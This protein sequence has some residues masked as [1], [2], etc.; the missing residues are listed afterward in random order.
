[1]IVDSESVCKLRLEG[2]R[3]HLLLEEEGSCCTPR[4]KMLDV[5]QIEEGDVSG[6]KWVDE[7]AAAMR[8]VCGRLGSRLVWL[9]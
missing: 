5:E 8:R 1:M 2:S 4:L 6:D 7:T 3:L 9:L